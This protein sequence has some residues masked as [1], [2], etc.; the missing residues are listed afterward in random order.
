MTALRR[1]GQLVDSLKDMLSISRHELNIVASP[2][3]M[4]AGGALVFHFSDQ[5]TLPIDSVTFP[6]AAK[7]CRKLIPSLGCSDTRFDDLRMDR[8]S[9]EA[10]LACRGGE[11]GSSPVPY[12]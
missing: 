3:G 2:K 12:D 5:T 6:N 10:E 7:L 8:V 4:V 9:H 1:L 11:R